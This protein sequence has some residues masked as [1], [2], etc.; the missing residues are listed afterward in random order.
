MGAF[1]EN[2]T[3]GSVCRKLLV[4]CPSAV[5]DRPLKGF[6]LEVVRNIFTG[7]APYT[8]D[9]DEYKAV[10]AVASRFTP[11]LFILKKKV[12]L[13]GEPLDVKKLLHDC[14]GNY[15]VDEYNT[16]LTLE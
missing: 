11:V 5:K 2:A 13:G 8:E 14:L 6:M 4:K 12:K 7:N 1:V 15:G 10:M 3:L 9:T 16:T